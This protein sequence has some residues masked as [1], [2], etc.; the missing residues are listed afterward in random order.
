MSKLTNER[1]AMALP[2]PACLSPYTPVKTDKQ[3]THLEKQPISLANLKC[4]TCYNVRRSDD[5]LHLGSSL[6]D[7]ERV[8]FSQWASL[9]RGR[10]WS[11][12]LCCGEMKAESCGRCGML[13]CRHA[14]DSPWIVMEADVLIWCWRRMSLSMCIKCSSVSFSACWLCSLP[15]LKGTTCSCQTLS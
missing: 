2:N 7:K 6:L 15:F 14:S 13:H 8:W 9:S 1:Q 11:G 10:I 12:E 4:T 5:R 3:R